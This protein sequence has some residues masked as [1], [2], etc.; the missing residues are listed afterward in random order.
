MQHSEAVTEQSRGTLIR[1]P[2]FVSDTA[3]R[4]AQ[5]YVDW[6]GSWMPACSSGA[7]RRLDSCAPPPPAPVLLP[8]LL[9]VLLAALDSCVPPPP[10]PVLLPPLLAVLMA[11]LD[12]CVLLPVLATPALPPLIFFRE[13]SAD[14][15]VQ[16]PCCVLWLPKC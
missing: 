11:A 6:M 3:A 10:A 8:P 12:S 14:Y 13:L 4:G 1:L 5:K 16:A 15:L 7:A 2:A 9:A